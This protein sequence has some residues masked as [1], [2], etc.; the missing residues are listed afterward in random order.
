MRLRCGKHCHSRSDCNVCAGI[1]AEEA[2]AAWDLFAEE[3]GAA[4]NL[5]AEE[6]VRGE[7]MV[8]CGVRVNCPGGWRKSADCA[9]FQLY[10]DFGCGCGDLLKCGLTRDLLKCGCLMNGCRQN[11]LLAC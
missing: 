9:R 3:A 7:R 10:C 8:R 4:W 11:L 2:G 1:R 6:A 5:L